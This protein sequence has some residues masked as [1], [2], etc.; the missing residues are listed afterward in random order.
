MVFGAA[1][2]VGEPLT[3]YDRH[4]LTRAVKAPDT[5]QSSAL[6]ALSYKQVNVCLSIPDRAGNQTWLESE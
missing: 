1:L 6:L 3:I 2:G 5:Q 4:T